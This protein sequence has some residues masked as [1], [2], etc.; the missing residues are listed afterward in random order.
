MTHTGSVLVALVIVLLATGSALAD[1]SSARSMA[2]G[3]AYSA[4]ASGIDAARYNPANL[5]LN[6][7][8]TK[9][10]EIIGL[11]VDIS[12][13]SL[14]LDDYNTYTGAVL[15][16]SDKQDIL[17]KIPDEGLRLVAQVE[18]SA[19]GLAM[20]SWAVTS[21]VVGVADVNLSKDIMD[22]VLN[23]NSLGQTVSV[24]GSYSDAVGYAQTAFSYGLPIYQSGSRQVS[25]GGSVKYVRGLAVEQVIELEGG[26]TT[27]ATGF[28]GAGH[29]IARTATG[30]SGFGVDLG[31]A[32]RFNDTYT[33]GLNVK[34]ILGSISWTNQTEEHGYAFDF[35]SSATDVLQSDYVVSSDYTKDIAS[36]STSLPTVMTLGLA[37][38]KGQLHWAI[39]W[40]QGFQ[41][42]AG[43]ST[44][45]RIAAGVEWSK[46]SVLPL[47][48][49]YATGGGRGANFSIGTGLNLG[50]FYFDVATQ[51]GGSISPSSSR[52]LSVAF[53]TGFGF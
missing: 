48:A 41:R 31:A 35:D 6:G 32:M 25:V 15:T 12:N 26:V 13:N 4:L 5:G 18:A 21:G 44:K 11:G 42:A 7:Y 37:D 47:R 33:V 23:G 50:G 10:F 51:T 38:N 14:S 36:F 24:T 28:T 45:P 30:G 27:M 43:S 9:G 39:D 20:G 1:G 16:T 53:A 46:I 2:M 49:G 40:Q 8:Q 34:N 17:G 22:L 52:G 3:G 19:F 29:M